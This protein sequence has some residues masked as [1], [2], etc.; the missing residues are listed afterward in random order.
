MSSAATILHADLD[1]FY[2]SVAVRED[3][4]LAGKPVAV[5][6]G[7]ILAATYEARRF[8]VRSAMSG[9]DARRRCPELVVV[10]A[11]FEL[12]V[13]TSKQVMAILD[14]FTPLVEAISIDEAFL[15][16]SGSVHLFGPPPQI[17]RQIRSAV[18]DEVRLPISVGV[19]STKHLA[20][21][22]SRVAKP[23][24]LVVVEP[25]TEESFLR[26][27]PVGH[28]WGVGPVGEERLRQY[29]IETIGD[30]ADLPPA[31][32]SAWMGP[33][34]GLHLSALARN[35]DPRHV[36]TERH[37]GSIGAQSAVDATDPDRR[38]R[39]LLG[40][41]ERI[42]TRMRRKELA[43]RRVTVRVRFGDMSAVT[44]AVTLPGPISETSAIYR[45]ASRLVDAVVG[46]R[47]DGRRI[48][49]VG[50]S[51]SGLEKAPDVQLE[52]PLGGLAEDPVARAGSVE[53]LRRHDLDAAVDRARERFGRGAVRRAA[54][55]G[56][57]TEE[58]SPTDRLDED[59]A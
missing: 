54:L 16:V 25:G 52:L 28:L 13:E 51:V 12:Y 46:E 53:N 24:G 11:R 6:G 22:A 59:Q 48:S 21:I 41:A 55:L 44:R 35:E 33:H 47:G 2:A 17:A 8:G 37:A 50:I 3:P 18:R 30:L 7:V 20:K 10:P 39:T 32:L 40:L 23:D 5:G 36:T 45:E 14:R 4:S 26:P 38:H 34:W 29:G 27:L 15:D 49:L 19:A 42:G 31:T 43:G 57:D 58:R 9:A 1:A 56:E